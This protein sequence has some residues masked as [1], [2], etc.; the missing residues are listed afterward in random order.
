MRDGWFIAPIGSLKTESHAPV[1]CA[2]THAIPAILREKT[3]LH[4]RR[5]GYCKME[6]KRR[7]SGF[8]SFPPSRAMMAEKGGKKACATWCFVEGRWVCKYARGILRWMRG[9]EVS[10]SLK[11]ALR[12]YQ[13]HWIVPLYGRAITP[14][15]LILP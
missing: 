4:C 6:W 2:E 11:E 14:P 5:E 1:I 7:K 9:R 3:D 8:D 12:G 10:K 15:V 13:W